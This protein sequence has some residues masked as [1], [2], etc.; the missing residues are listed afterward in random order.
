[1]HNPANIY[2]ADSFSAIT[3]N[4]RRLILN[5]NGNFLQAFF[6][7]RLTGIAL[8]AN[9]YLYFSA[10]QPSLHIP[11]VRSGGAAATPCPQ[12]AAV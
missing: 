6:R 11:G 9:L 7:D 10:Q 3:L 5:E 1:M 4:S 12:R 8:P 2:H